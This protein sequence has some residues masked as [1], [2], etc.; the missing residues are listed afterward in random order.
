MNKDF[1]RIKEE[2]VLFFD[3]EMV[4]RNKELEIDSVEYSLY[5]K[6]TRNRETDEFLCDEDLKKE[7]EKRAALKRGYNKIITIGVGF[8]KDGVPYI[9]DISGDEGFVIKEFVKIANQFK[10]NCS[11]NGIAFDLP[12]IV[13]NGMKYFNIAEE[14]K[15]PFNPSGKKIWNMDMCIDL[16][17]VFKGS[18][19]YPN[20][21]DEVCYHFDIPTPKDDISGAEVSET[22]YNGDKNRIY[23]YVKKDV[24]ANINIFRKMQGKDIFEDFVDRSDTKEPIIEEKPVLERIYASNSITSKDKEDIKKLVGKK[25]LTKKDKE[26]LFTIIRGVYVQTDFIASKVDTKK[27]ITQKEEEINELIKTL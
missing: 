19:Y 5:Q 4:R 14:L 2:D 11:F 25:K 1:Q 8:I 9:K 12:I 18:H 27:V 3:G 13:G 24:F 16:L 17:E 15:D 20:S 6:K 21:L 22:Y 23:E 7:Y 26:N 10:Y